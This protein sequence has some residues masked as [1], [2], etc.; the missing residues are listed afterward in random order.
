MALDA[1]RAPVDAERTAFADA[2]ERAASSIVTRCGAEAPEI[3]S[4]LSDVMRALGVPD[5]AEGWT[6]IAEAAARKVA[7]GS[8]P[9]ARPSDRPAARDRRL[10]TRL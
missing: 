5:Q 2:V 7:A 9:L 10:R 3:A 4:W 1:S 6:L 8:G